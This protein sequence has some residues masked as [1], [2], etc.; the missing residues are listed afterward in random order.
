MN[1]IFQQRAAL[2]ASLLLLIAL[3]AAISAFDVL[4]FHVPRLV[5][6]GLM[7]LTT[8]VF[9]ALLFD[10]FHAPFRENARWM[11]LPNFTVVLLFSISAIR[12]ASSSFSVDDEIYS[13]N[14]WAIQH[15]SGL[16]ADFQF[17]GAPYPQLFSYW[18]AA[19]YHAMGSVVTQSVPRFFLALSTLLVG[20]SVLGNLK[21][22]NWRLAVF[23]SV[24]VFIVIAPIAPWYAKGLADPLMTAA[25]ALSAWLLFEYS[26]NPKKLITLALSLACG[27]IGAVTKQAALIWCCFSLPIIV[28][29]GSW[30]YRWPNAA[31]GLATFALGAALIWPLLIAP[32]FSNNQGVIAASMAGRTYLQQLAFAIKQFLFNRPEIL[33]LLG[34]SAIVAWRNALARIIALVAVLP[35]LI[36][37]FLFGAYSLRLGAHVLAVAGVILVSALSVRVA[38]NCSGLGPTTKRGYA[39]VATAVFAYLFLLV[40]G[41]VAVANKNG[42]DLGDGAQTTLQ[43]QFGHDAK[44]EIRGLLKNAPR[45]WVTSNYTYGSLYGRVTLGYPE[46]SVPNYSEEV[47]KS[48]LLAFKPDYAIF[49]GVVPMGPASDLL[50]KLAD[51][52]PTALVPVLRPP[53]Q[54]EFILYRV[55]AEKLVKQECR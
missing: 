10:L 51:D 22:T 40:A 19:L 38:G 52:C 12:L 15:F 47:A 44:A 6:V 50:K 11:L 31:I 25:M 29:I 41:I 17:T 4:A 45:I 48:Q 27:V 34:A 18:I 54:K 20:V 9:G 26:K 42:S 13:W 21:A 3:S 46:Y 8:V 24:V 37:W 1:K 14:L 30:R 32:D 49:S 53:N 16:Q 33:L 23:A 2:G 35:M 5:F 43:I 28:L 55:S 39:F 36:A 7:A